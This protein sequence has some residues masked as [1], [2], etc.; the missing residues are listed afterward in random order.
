MNESYVFKTKNGAAC[1]YI[2]ARG[3][4]LC[5]R[6]TENMKNVCL[7]VLDEDGEQTFDG[8]FGT[9]ETEKT[10]RGKKL[11]GAYGV[12]DGQLVM[13]TGETAR[14]AFEK[15]RLAA[16]CEKKKPVL[17]PADSMKSEPERQTRKTEK[18]ERRWPPPPCIPG[19]KYEKG[20]WIME[21]EVR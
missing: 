6:L 12:S 9:E 11:F 20:M 5:I 4:K 3:K 13:D 19:A 21:T 18:S 15:R 16:D 14:K 1:G 7:T 8:N 17:Q 10:G 2:I